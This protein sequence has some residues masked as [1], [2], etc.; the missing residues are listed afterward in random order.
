MDSPS[1]DPGPVQPRGPA[2]ALKGEARR[3]REEARSKGQ[4]LSHAAALERVAHLRGFRDWNGLSA[5]IAKGAGQE[6]PV[7]TFAWQRLD[8]PLPKLPTRILKPSELKRHSSVTEVMRWARQLEFI[9]DKVAEGDRGEMM[10][11]IGERTP[12]VLERSNSRWPDGL[13]RLCDRG[14]DVFKGLT[15]SD[16]QVL[17]LGLPTWNDT[18]G[19]HDGNGSFTVVGDALRHTSNEKRLKQMARLLASLAMEADRAGVQAGAGSDA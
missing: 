14:Y 17:A 4:E 1:S 9:A 2:H 19:Q 16:D 6:V 3:L 10:E 12:Y 15:F 5:H 7:A 18:V 13:Y 8:E 11:L